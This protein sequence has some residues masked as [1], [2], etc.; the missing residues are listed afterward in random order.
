MPA[1]PK[2]I[3]LNLALAASLAAILWQGHAMWVEAQA[4]RR[5]TVNVPVKRVVPPPMIPAPR[6][7]AVQATKYADVAA[8]NL[9]SKDRN[10]TV[11]VDAPKVEPPKVMPPF[12]VV[13]GV[14]GLPSGM[15]AI[16]AERA[17]SQSRSVRT[18]DTVGEFKILALDTR[19]VTFE[20]DGKQLEKSLDDLTDRS[21]VAASGTSL[22]MSGPAA[23]PPPPSQVTANALGPAIG[24]DGGTRA[25]KSDD[26][27]PLGT[28]VDGYKKTGFASPFGITGC[29]WTK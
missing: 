15:K 9:F 17:G 13:Y 23:P 12:P 2:L 1:K 21:G 5:A 27:S 7:E 8:K 22:A 16:M 28:V 20:W 11:I 24:T 14:L 3:A 25:C 18:G 29:Q 26:N 10:P 4:E 6:P 19:K